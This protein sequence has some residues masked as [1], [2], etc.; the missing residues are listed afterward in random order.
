MLNFYIIYGLVWI[1]AGATL[2]GLGTAQK[3]N[4]HDRLDRRYVAATCTTGVCLKY[5][6]EVICELTYTAGEYP[7]RTDDRAMGDGSAQSYEY[8][9][10]GC[11][12][13]S[14]RLY[15]DY[16][17]DNKYSRSVSDITVGVANMIMGAIVL[18]CTV[19]CTIAR[20]EHRCR[21]LSDDPLLA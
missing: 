13:S 5:G 19:G 2:Y 4:R 12:R 1:A 16:E 18:T 10:H 6:D 21:A 14:N 7:N 15:S 20:R 8:G 11:W 9:A 17:Y 3:Q